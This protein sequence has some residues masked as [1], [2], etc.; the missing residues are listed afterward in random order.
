MLFTVV[1]HSQCLRSISVIKIMLV[2]ISVHRETAKF[3]DSAIVLIPQRC[4]NKRESSSSFPCLS[5]LPAAHR[6][7]SH[8]TH[9]SSPIVDPS[10]SHSEKSSPFRLLSGL[11]WTLITI[12]LLFGY[13]CRPNCVIVECPRILNGLIS[14]SATRQT[15]YSTD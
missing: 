8:F 11:S 2:I 12:A 9:L 13:F 15:T 4:P 10:S 3:P 7:L 1:N 6:G 5:T 14:C